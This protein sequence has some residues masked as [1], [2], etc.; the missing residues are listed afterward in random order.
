MRPV[1]VLIR[2]EFQQILRD[3][4]MLA[5]IFMIPV[6]QLF[7]LGY[8][9]TTDVKHLKLA[10]LD[11]DRSG[12]ARQIGASL[13]H[14]G[15]FDLVGWAE[16]RRQVEAW[17]QDGKADLGILIPLHFNAGLETGRSPAVQ[18]LV[19]GQNSNTSAIGLG[20]AT[21]ILQEISADILSSKQAV[22]AQPQPRVHLVEAK[23]RIFYNPDL[24][25]V[26][27]MIPGVVTVLLTVTTMMLTG[28]GLVRE[29]E[30][31]TFEQLMVTPILPAQ[32]LMGKLIPFA[33][34][35][36][37]ELSL[38]LSIGAVWFHLPF[39]GN[40]ALVALATVLFLMTT[41]GIGL[42]VSTISST[43]QQALFIGWFIMI[44]GMLMSGFF[45]ALENMPNWAQMLTLLNPLRY[46]LAI[47]REVFLKGSSLQQ[48]HREFVALAVIG[49]SVLS[50]TVARFRARIG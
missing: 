8:A 50:L 7:L 42:F 38:A 24:K 5:I 27:Y 11:E 45:Y 12:M 36:F 25:S 22:K 3:R 33:I 17:I 1:L 46:Y 29:K 9:V 2:K 30:I 48:L 34:L 31:G 23:T 35:G 40:L 16:S 13:E 20:Y 43:Q 41:L 6:V 28:M 37:L 10:I 44:F 26:Y 15:Y 32:L 14:C 19:D 4:F 49:V 39:E 18:I 21:R 47:L